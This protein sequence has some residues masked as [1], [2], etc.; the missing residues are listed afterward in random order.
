[1][2][3][4]KA[5]KRILALGTGATMVGATIMSA[6]G[7]ADLAT[8][9]APFVENGLFNAVIIVGESGQTTDVIGAVDIAT[10]LQYSSQT[11]TTVDVSGG[12]N[13]QVSQG[14]KVESGSQPLRLGLNFT[15]LGRTIFTSADLDILKTSSFQDQQGTAYTAQQKIQ[16]PNAFV[17]YGRSAPSSD[18][19]VDEPVLHVNFDNGPLGTPT[20]QYTLIIDF[21]TVID[22]TN[23]TN[24]VISLFGREYTTGASASE[25]TS[26]KMTLYQSAVDQTFTAGQEAVVDVKGQKVTVRVI[27]VNTQATPATVTVSVNGETESLTKGQT[28]TLG[29][30]RV[31]VRDVQAYTQPVGGG[32]ARLFIGSEKLVFSEGSNVEKGTESKSVDGTNVTVTTS[33]GKISRIAIGVRPRDFDTKS[34]VLLEGQEFV[35]PVF[36]TF[37]WLFAKP[38]SNPDLMAA[39]KSKIVLQPSEDKLR[40]S[41][42]NKAGAQYDVDIFKGNGTD[43]TDGE[44]DTLLM[45]ANGDNTKNFVTVASSVIK[46]NDYFVIG[47]GEYQ[48]IL[49]LSSIRNTSSEKEITVQDVST[50][51]GSQDWSWTGDGIASSAGTGTMTY[52]GNSYTFSLSM[53]TVAGAQG[54]NIS[55][56]STTNQIYTDNDNLITLPLQNFD[57]IADRN[58]STNTTAGSGGGMNI[59]ITEKTTYSTGS[60]A[61]DY[62]T[63]NFTYAYDNAKTGQDL[64]LLSDPTY[65]R[66]STGSTLSL[67][68]NGNGLFSLS[69]ESPGSNSNDKRDLTPWGTLILYNSDSNNQGVTLYMP[70]EQTNYNVFV[71]PAGATA[72][73]GGAGEGQIVVPTINPIQVGAAVLPSEVSDFTNVNSVVVGGPC[74]NSDAAILL[75]SPAVCTE[76]FEEGKAMLRLFT[77]PSGKVALL[78]A[79]YSATDTRRAARVIAQYKTYQASGKLQG[80]N[81]E[82]T[83]VNADFTDTVVGAA[84]VA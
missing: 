67:A 14:V 41:F 46:R 76:G 15:G 32:G 59:S 43:T 11:S 18:Q 75:G 66:A 6:M 2:K 10:S 21:P 40:L 78:V 45:R 35:D 51:G 38:G 49:K 50:G 77:H 16:L 39:T 3:L 80:T 22:P 48:R 81:V 36:G 31:Y 37:K 74:V 30:Q 17:A 69:F 68:D 12:D 4:R 61:D 5:V 29:G 72:T 84:T 24:E 47:S 70:S 26:T 25:M 13:V 58:E 8:Y 82:V 62:G 33:S 1:M 53:D 55:S 19:N 28:K 57:H 63:I 20:P 60:K 83:G 44:D 79:G 71:A 27:G 54:G 65:G 9:P 34:G 42:K 73:A 56:A 64:Y 7:A 52:D 23:L